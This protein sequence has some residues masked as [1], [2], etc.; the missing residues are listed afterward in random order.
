MTTDVEVPV[1]I[2]AGCRYFCNDP[3]FLENAIPGLYSM[4]SA[5]ASV[6]RD[7][8]VCSMHERYLSAR[9]SCAEFVQ[10]QR[11]P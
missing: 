11:K 4:S 5:F 2:C 8:G 7:D 3:N 9:S 6:R 1:K 10:I